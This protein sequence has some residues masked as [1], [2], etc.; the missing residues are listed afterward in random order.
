MWKTLLRLFKRPIG[1]WL[2]RRA[3]Y[4]SDEDLNRIAGDDP[5]MRML[6]KLAY[7]RLIDQLQRQWE[8]L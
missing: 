4:L 3:L 6:V 1:E 8:E 5:N 7:R 2:F